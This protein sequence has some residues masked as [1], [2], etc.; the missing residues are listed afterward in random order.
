MTSKDFHCMQAAMLRQK[1]EAKAREEGLPVDNIAALSPEELQQTLHEL[2][3]HQIQLEM[4]NEELRRTHA[5]LDA[6]RERY[7]DL[8]D[9][10]PVGYVTLSDAGVIL[11][12][13]FTAATL[14]GIPRGMLIRQ[15]F[16]RFILSPE[17][18][19]HFHHH[20]RQG[21]DSGKPC[22]CELR[23]ARPDHTVFWAHLVTTVIPAQTE[24]AP[25]CRIVLSDVTEHKQTEE[26]LRD[27]EERF[28]KVLHDVQSVAIQG[29]GPDG[30]V[31]HWNEASE[32]LYGYSA[33][34]AL[35]R[36]LTDL[37]IPP[38]MREKVEQAIRQMAQTGQPIPAAELSLMRKDGSRVA[39]YS[40]HAVVQVAGRGSE[41]FC[42][43]IDLTPYKQIETALRESEE[44]HRLLFEA[45]SDPL[46]LFDA[47]TLQIVNANR[48]A[49]ALYGYDQD[50]LFAMKG[51]ELSAEPE[52][53]SRVLQ[54]TMAIPGRITT[55][56]L[57]LHRK[58]DGTVFPVEITGRTIPFGG[59]QVV[60]VAIRDISKQKRIEAVMAARLSLLQSADSQ[61]LA[62][63]L[64]ATLDEAEALTNSRIGFYHFME[65][66]Q[67][68]L[69]L[70]AWS[71]NTLAHMC[72]AEGAGLHYPVSQAGVWVECFHQRR[73]VI[74]NDYD[75]LPHRKGLPPGHAP[76][77]RE[78]VV[79]VL[80]GDSVVALLGVGNKATN[81][82]QDDVEAVTALADL[83]WEIAERKQAEEALRE[84]DER[85]RLLFESVIDAL[86]LIDPETLQIVK[87][88]RRATELYGYSEEE[89]LA[90]RCL[91]LAVDPEATLES[92]REA[93]SAP[94]TLLNIPLRHHRKKDGTVFPVEITGRT[95][96]L[97]GQ[98]IIFFA[99]RDISERKRV[100]AALRHSEEQR[101]QV[102]QAANA[103]L[104]EQADNLQSI[105]QALDSVG[106]IVCT[107]EDG[108]G[109]IA[110]FN[111]GAEKMFGYRQEEA[112]GRSIALI[113]P[114]EL[115]EIIPGRV[116]KFAQGKSMQ[117]FDMP[118]CRRSGERF[119]AVVSVHP[120]DAHE[121]QFRKVVGVFRDISELM[122]MQEQ[123]KLANSEL[124]RRV[125]QRTRE[126]Q[127]TQ[128]QYLHAEKLSAI[129]K[130]SASI[131]HEFNNPLQGIL[132]ILK[133]VKKRAILAKED[134]DLLEAAVG[135]GDRIKELIRSLQEFNRPSSSRKMLMDVHKSLDSMLLLHKSDFRGKRISVVRDYAEQLP[136]I[137]AVPD[138]IK[139]VFL[140]LLTNAADACQQPGGVITVSTWQEND[141]VAVAIKD[142]GIGIHPE[143]MDL[144]FQPFY[145]TKPAV[146][147]TGL[148]L[149]VSYGI[150]KDHG[151]EILVDSQ[152]GQ[153]A[154][155]TVLL[156]I[157]GQQNAIASNGV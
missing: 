48:R 130:L 144:I 74:H 45:A 84:S 21:T 71:T 53:T 10:A 89:L 23:M 93:R 64:Q 150:V 2:R 83:G 6:A 76:V 119:P 16:S 67:A 17:E 112:I 72:K 147:G 31:Q 77:V 28:R 111:A 18:C 46:F 50:E 124:E 15:P 145:T 100:E 70:H 34:E 62:E 14:L 102:Q 41:L 157:K 142:T 1:A 114:P 35:G 148:G 131:A 97:R 30:T 52:E 36:N 122:Q 116:K 57:R 8:Y 121:G 127:E 105:Y 117:S 19:D 59:R 42:I 49:V 99:A 79:P 96:P 58:K 139:Q 140:N 40:S 152:P 20:C 38:E 61:T 125:E 94:N 78:L 63:L 103:M 136:Q 156:P 44:R 135:E 66:D 11:E 134:R 5:E 154:T 4:Q 9:L 107:L 39:V 110:V 141:Q 137:M 65:A 129:G 95:I 120:C 90:M 7:F 149:S 138:Q 143:M 92:V 26:A 118:L 80:R 146:K 108:D 73:P 47:D 51:V 133:G 98:D 32:R 132:S 37:I 115:V 109:R 128:K 54:E 55:V 43:D 33:R 3:V 86:F 113:Y 81:Y 151:G 88:N 101:L 153:G 126:L 75:A 56:P 68:T 85:Y 69:T 155:F 104:K 60:F 123:L 82:N 12:A 106:L 87:V 29:Y 27:S 13:N 22:M 91:D 25:M 24:G